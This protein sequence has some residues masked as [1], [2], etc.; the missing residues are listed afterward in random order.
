VRQPPPVPG[1]AGGGRGGARALLLRAGRPARAALRR[2][3]VRAR[4]GEREMV[5]ERTA[6]G[7]GGARAGHATAR[8]TV[9]AAVI[10]AGGRQVTVG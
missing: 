8:R 9:A 4:R 3:R 5:E 6:V 2:R 10:G 1:A 7:C